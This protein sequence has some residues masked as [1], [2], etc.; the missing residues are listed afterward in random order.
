MVFG[1]WALMIAASAA[2]GAEVTSHPIAELAEF[3]LDE[4]MNLNVEKVYGASKFEQDVTEAPASVTVVTAEE[5]KQY[6]WRTL[7]DILNATRGFFTSYDRNYHYIGVRGFSRPGDYNSRV[8]LLIDGHRLNDSIYETAHIGTDFPLD[9]ALI[10]RI[11]IVRGPNSSLYGTS[12][13]F[14][15]ISVIT[16]SLQE[17]DG[18]EASVAVGDR[19]TGKG[20]ERAGHLGTDLVTNR[21]E[22]A[23]YYSRLSY[24]KAFQGGGELLLSASGYTSDGEPRLFYPE[25]AQTT[26][27]G[28]ADQLDRDRSYSFFGK[29]KFGDVTLTGIWHNRD[30]TVPTASFATLP[31]DPGLRT[32]DSRGFLDL[33]FERPVSGTQLMARLFLDEYRLDS[34]YPG[35]F[36]QAGGPAHAINHDAAIGRWWGGEL[37]ASRQI[38]DWLHFT[39]GSEYRDNFLQDQDNSDLYPGGASFSEQHDNAF[40]SLYSQAEVRLHPKLILNAGVRHDHYSTFGG[41]TSPRVALICTP[42]DKTVFKA[43]YG[44][45]FRSP[46]AYELYYRDTTGIAQPNPL[47]KPEQ[48]RT[49]ELTWE[50]YYGEHLRSSISGYYSWIRDL[51]TYQ[52]GV[53][54]GNIDRI[55]SA[56]ADVELEG[57]WKNG[58]KT[59]VSYSF[60]EAQ[61]KTADRHLDN[62]PQHLAKLNLTL[63]LYRKLLSAGLEV[64]WVGRRDYPEKKDRNGTTVASGT[65]GSYVVSN[66]TLL[67]SELLKGLD[68]S[69]SVYNLFDRQFADPGTSDHDQVLIP[70]DGRTFRVMMTYRF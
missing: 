21:S 36:T 48:I 66:L 46:S 16:R 69:A 14:G 22:R 30:K 9:L 31:N 43:S 54:W 63:P 23:S 33:K 13:F 56:G 37:Q 44:E 11:E 18:V 68:L 38:M 32:I 3:S 5:I 2:W 58:I 50:Q 34:S 10:E 64:Q 51:I 59:R 19:A 49:A 65:V 24:G 28:N 29:A 52:N 57:H 61:D 40:W 6:G 70:Q 55:E 47:L 45:A 15:V 7:A 8:L 41:N 53:P 1:A 26:G 62:S 27:I 12:A 4:L 39:V 67:S 17:V 20:L 25:L 60:V 35:D 42:V